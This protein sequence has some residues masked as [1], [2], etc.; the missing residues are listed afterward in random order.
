LFPFTDTAP[1]AARPL[2]VFGLIAVNTLVFLW[3]WDM[4]LREQN[5]ILVHYALIPIRYTNPA[6]A[7]RLGLDPANWWPLLTNTFLHGGWL[8][9]ISNMWFLWIFGPAMEGRLGRLMFLALYL[10]GGVAASAVHVWTH[11]NSTEPVLGASGA[12]AAVI[13]AHAITFPRE[14]VVMVVLLIII[15]L[16]FS[17]PTVAFA[18]IWF[19]L[20]IIQGTSELASPGMASSVAWWAHIGGFGFGA[21]F[22]WVVGA[23]EFD[24]GVRTATWSGRGRHVPLI[25]PRTWL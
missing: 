23:F 18:L 20:Q 17:V 10:G 25:K 15:P 19:A 3:M 14:R 8:H 22:A 16:F 13:A 6:V 21:L 24:S 2:V 12:I 4:P 5:G 1:R 7:V 9:L 11:A